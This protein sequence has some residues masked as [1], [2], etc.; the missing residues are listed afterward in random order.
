MQTLQQYPT[1]T[2][3]AFVLDPSGP[4]MQRCDA[5]CQLHHP[6]KLEIASLVS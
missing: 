2:L 4:A 5:E 6:Q 3:L 1:H